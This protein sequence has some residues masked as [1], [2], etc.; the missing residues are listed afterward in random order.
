MRHVIAASACALAL[1]AVSGC[2]GGEASNSGAGAATE[3]ITRDFTQAADALQAKLGAP[4]EKSDLPLASD[5][6]VQAFETQSARALEA[7]GTPRLPVDGFE[8]FDT[9]CMKSANIVGAYVGAGG[10]ANDPAV[11]QANVERYMDQMFTPLLFSAHCSAVHMP[12]L[13]ETVSQGEVGDK[14]AALQQVRDGAFAQVAG[15]M[16]MAAASE[17]GAEE[18]QRI[19]DLLANDAGEFAVAL[20]RSQRQQLLSMVEQMKAALPPEAASK[21]E[22]I[23]AAFRRADCGTL[24][25]I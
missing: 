11:Q 17:S 4:G 25:S 6:A 2:D 19:L 15:L 5:P 23:G 12:F 1:L 22:T 9:F 20:S 3:E 18:R 21:A 14:A 13:E 16:Q 24:C 7:L 10:G 8:T